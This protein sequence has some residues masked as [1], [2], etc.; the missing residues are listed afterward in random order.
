MPAKEQAGLKFFSFCAAKVRFCSQSFCRFR[1]NCGRIYCNGNPDR[2]LNAATDSLVIMFVSRRIIPLPVT[3]N[4]NN[5]IW[6]KTD[7]RL[8]LHSQKRK[9]RSSKG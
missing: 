1:T 8:S 7:T 2:V 6:L 9:A 4:T 3:S 5:K